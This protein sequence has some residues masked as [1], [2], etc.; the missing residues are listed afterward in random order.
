ML[1]ELG[2]RS[3]EDWRRDSRLTMLYKAV[4]GT[5]ALPTEHILRPAY[6]RTRHSYQYKYQTIATNCDPYKYSFFPRTSPDWNGLD[7]QVMAAE[8]L[9]QFKA[10]LAQVSQ[11]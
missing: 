5:V 4:H 9:G 2:W 10:E 3:L 8:T 6:S 1:D 7:N 11:H